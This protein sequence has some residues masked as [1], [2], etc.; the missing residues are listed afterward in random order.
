VKTAS[1]RAGL[2]AEMAQSRAGYLADWL[3]SMAEMSVV[4]RARLLA[5]QRAG[6]MV[7]MWAASW[8]LQLVMLTVGVMAVV[9]V[10]S[11]A[12]MWV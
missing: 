4:L 7:G 10:E 11:K 12:E 9:W 8:V 2:K 6:V 3:E 5:A 1:A